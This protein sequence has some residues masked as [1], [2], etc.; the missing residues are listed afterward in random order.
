MAKIRKSGLLLDNDGSAMIEFV[1]VLPALLM[2][3]FAIMDFGRL[4]FVK[5]T[6]NRAASDAA[7][8]LAL[9]NNACPTAA[10]AQTYAAQ[11]AWGLS[12]VT[13]TATL[14]ACGAQVA[15]A[16][17]FEF[18]IPYWSGTNPLPLSATAC[19]PSQN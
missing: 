17:S 12:G 18:V 9:N 13:F 15:A 5:T 2:L 19:Y 3:T 7:R 16:Y 8:C 11:Q 4:F 1:L 6:L 14:P 10:N